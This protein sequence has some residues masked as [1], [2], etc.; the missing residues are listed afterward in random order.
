PTDRLSGRVRSRPH[1]HGGR[2]SAS[3][4]RCGSL[5]RGPGAVPMSGREEERPLTHNI[6]PGEEPLDIEAYLQAGGYA[7]VRKSFG[8]MTP[9]AVIR[10]V[11]ASNLRGRGG[12][13]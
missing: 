2:G 8:G 10:E 5:G 12:A 7:A 11:T 1:D 9:E 6:R 4:P 3:R 13:G